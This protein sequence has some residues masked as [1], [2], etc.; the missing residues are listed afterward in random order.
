MKMKTFFIYALV[1]CAAIIG[2]KDDSPQ[3]LNPPNTN[4]FADAHQFFPTV[5]GNKWTYEVEV[6]DTSGNKTLFEEIGIYSKDS[7]ALNIYR[8]GVLWS[9]MY[10]TNVGSKL[11]CCRDRILLDYSNIDCTTDSVQLYSKDGSEPLIW[12]YQICDRFNTKGMN[13]YD[14]IDCIKTSQYNTY[15]DGSGLHITN[16]FG[17]DVG[18]IYRQ[19]LSLDVLGSVVK[20]ETMRLKSHSF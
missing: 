4:P 18:L 7:Q 8:N 6:S 5:D 3:P 12:I 1:I 11:T 16:Y 2:C 9:M 14:T 17:Y 19:Q 15:E 10:W 20:Q 13:D